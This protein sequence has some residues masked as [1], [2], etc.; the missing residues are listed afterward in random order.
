MTLQSPSTMNCNFPDAQILVVD[1][2]LSARC[3]LVD[4]FN[5]LGY[6]ASGA[7]SGQEA[8]ECLSRRRFDL[9]LLDLNMPGMNGAEVLKIGHP[10]A[11]DTVFIVLTGHGTLDSAIV[12]VRQGA[13]D[14][15]LKP[16]PTEEIVRV[17]AAGLNERLQ[18][19]YPDNPVL[20]LERA[21]ANL[22]NATAPSKATTLSERLLQTPEITVDTFK[23]LVVVRNQPVE[24][25]KTEYDV[26]VYLMRHQERVVSCNE[27]VEHLR[28]YELDE[29]DARTYMRS[30]VRRLRQKIELDPVNPRLIHTVRERGYTFS[31]K[32][33]MPQ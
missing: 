1:D 28:G 21:L 12:A 18:R 15:L 30:H 31:T 3:I 4:L 14:Y 6:Q 33:D 9:V 11:P 19:L 20:L 5:R 7:A 16:S 29:R 23:E 25:T 24:L 22:K 32:A 26:L 13:Y 27:L 2:E 10:L 8:L 17:V